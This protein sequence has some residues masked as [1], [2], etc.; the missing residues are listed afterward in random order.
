MEGMSQ[1]GGGAEGAAGAHC[2]GKGKEGE[3]CVSDAA[4]AESDTPGDVDSDDEFESEEEVDGPDTGERKG[5]GEGGEEEEEEE[6]DRCAICL[7]SLSSEPTCSL[8]GCGHSFHSSCIVA[9][10]QHNRAC[11]LC[12]YAPSSP[13]SDGESGPD[14]ASHPPP[15]V[16]SEERERAIRSSMGRARYGSAPSPVRLA[17][18][19]YRE[20]G[21]RLRSARSA[22]ATTSRE[23]QKRRRALNSE[24]LRLIR[25]HG[26]AGMPIHRRWFADRER[27]ESLE[28]QRRSLG[29]VL[30]ME[31][32]YRGE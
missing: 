11:P 5:E 7:V 18:G 2:G 24:Y 27:V 16:R 13:G 4:A 10:L 26:R 6:E 14:D 3:G 32:G 1:R 17:A 30:A 28:A 8:T 9:S 25:R 29:D 12:R 23:I 22:L 21:A 19:E 31:G 20:T 15:P